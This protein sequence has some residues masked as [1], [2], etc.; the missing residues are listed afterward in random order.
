MSSYSFD[1]NEQRDYDIEQLKGEVST[2]SGDIMS[3]KQRSYSLEEDS[4]R[5]ENGFATLIELLQS[6]ELPAD[7]RN[8]L[9]ELVGYF[10]TPKKTE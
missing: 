9:G 7:A 5:Y 2:Y 1:P 3:L 6:M 8:S 4:M 10:C